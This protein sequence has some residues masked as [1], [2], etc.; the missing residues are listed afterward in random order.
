MTLNIHLPHLT[1]SVAERF[2]KREFLAPASVRAGVLLL[3]NMLSQQGLSL[4]Q[5][6]GFFQN[7]LPAG[8]RSVALDIDFECVKGDMQSHW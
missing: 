5:F 3:L 1:S 6:A 2:A 4:K 7:T 8:G